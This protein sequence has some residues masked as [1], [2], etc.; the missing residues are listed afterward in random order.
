[1]TD[2]RVGVL[3][4]VGVLA[5]DFFTGVLGDG[6]GIIDVVLTVMILSRDGTGIWDFF[7]GVTFCGVVK[8]W[9]IIFQEIP[10]VDSSLKCSK[11]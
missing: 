9:S 11:H 4:L 7:L 2:V 8:S 6:M 1:M 5:V 10:T 3:H